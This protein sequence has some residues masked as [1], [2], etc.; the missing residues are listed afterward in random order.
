MEIG[1]LGGNFGAEIAG[2]DL[3]DPL[4]PSARDYVGK[5]FADNVVLCFRGQCFEKPDE[6]VAAASTLGEPMPPIVATYRL[7]GYDVVEELSND[8]TDKR[9]GDGKPMKRGG[10]W[11]SDHSNLETP[12]KATVLFAIEVPDGG[13]NTEFVNMY[14]AYDALPQMLKDK[15]EGRRAFQAYLSRRA[16]RKL[17][18]RN[19][20]EEEKSPGAWQPLVRLHPDTGRKAL[21]LNPM[22]IDAVEGMEQDTG[23]ALLDALYAHCDDPAFHYSHKW[24]PGDMLIWDNRSSMHRATFDFDPTKRRY[25]HRIMLKGDKPVLAA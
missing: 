1:D 10:S 11:H 8:A 21:Y 24:Q 14:D 20:A 22:R 5:V 19:T 18:K 9:T 15:I 7:S 23:D 13:G 6:F 17:L 2:L 12:P 16:P 3:R 4:E 25:L